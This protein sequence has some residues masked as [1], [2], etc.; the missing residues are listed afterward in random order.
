MPSERLEE[1]AHHY[2]AIGGRSPYN[3]ITFR[4][5]DRLKAQL[6]SSGWPV[7]VYV[8]MRNWEPFL[9]ETI[10]RMNHEGA[11]H[12]VG[13]I[14]APHRSPTSWERYQLDVQRACDENNGGPQVEYPD[15]WHQHPLFLE[16]MAQRVEEASG[17][18]R[19]EWPGDVPL[20][21]TTHSIP[22]SM[23]ESCRYVE[24]TTE[25]SAGIAAILGANNWSVAYQSRSGDA[26]TPWLEPDVNDVIRQAA[27]QGVR[28]IVLAPVG[29]LC[30]HVEVLY[31][32]DVEARET[33]AAAG[34]MLHRAGTV[35][36]HPLFI[37]MLTE[38]VRA[39]AEPGGGGG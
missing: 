10:S 19:G 6:A 23:A 8:G 22:V 9:K 5:A 2:E 20:V 24:E 35:G 34:I 29:F 15:P 36:V 31:D 39:K 32:L 18:R 26:R 4:Q 13:V 33:A 7:P 25:S 14:M 21:F 16:A 38:L 37:R 3:E 27:G 17:F 12:A 1:V 30:D 28:G 11:R